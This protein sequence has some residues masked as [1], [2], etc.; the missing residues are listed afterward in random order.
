MAESKDNYKPFYFVGFILAL[1]ILC[2]LGLG[3]DKASREQK[4]QN[5]TISL[6][7][8]TAHVNSPEVTDSVVDAIVVD[9][10]ASLEDE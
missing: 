5:D 4:V 7:V 2:I 6:V 9:A 1:A 10:A 3:K 8:D